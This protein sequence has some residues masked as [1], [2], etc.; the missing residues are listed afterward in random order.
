MTGFASGGAF[1]LAGV[2]WNSTN[3][4]RSWKT[5]IV[6]PEPI[7][8]FYIFDSLN[9]LGVGGDFEF[10]ASKI[11][12][13]DGGSIWNYTE[14]GVFGIANSI[15]FRTETEAWSALG[16]V[17]SLLISTDAG[18]NWSLV[19]T[20]DGTRINDLLFVNNNNGW[21]VG[22]EGAIL[23]FNSDYVNIKSENNYLPALFSLYQNY[24]NPFNPSTVIR[25]SLTGNSFV[26]LKI[27]DVRGNEIVTLVNEKQ[28]RGSY[29]YQFSNDDYQLP[30]GVY[31]YRIS[32][33]DNQLDKEFF[34]SRKM[35]ILK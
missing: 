10:G 23:K 8:D 17:D 16:I 20:P 3:G 5:Q 15:G 27:F 30:S 11:R 1:D 2:M 24:P 32:A 7:H 29:N 33:R 22:K 25:Y 31:F 19:G 6:G 18:I 21:A 4:G 12:S 26:S 35:I 28:N 9:I 34:E 14:L 13:T